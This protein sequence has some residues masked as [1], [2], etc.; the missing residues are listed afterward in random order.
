[1][2]DQVNVAFVQQYKTNVELLLQQMGSRLRRAVTT[3]TYTGKAGKSVE[4]V[5]PVNAVKRTTR[6]GD[7][8][9][10]STP[11]DARWVFP[12]DYEWADLIDDQDKVRMLID[13]QSPYARNGANALGR[14]I[15]NEIIAAFF[16][17][18]Y[19]GEDGTGTVT[20]NAENSNNQVAVGGAGLTV[21]KLR[22][23]KKYL[24]AAD[25]DVDNDEL[26]VAI[27][28]EQ[29]D[30][31]L[32]E[33]QAINLDYTNKPALVDGRITAFMGFNFIHT[34]LLV[35]DA[36]PD[37]RV[38]CWAKSGMHLGV[39]NDITTRIEERADKS[40][41]TQV[42]VKGTFGATRLEGEKVVEIICDEA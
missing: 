27:T 35:E 32:N 19:V 4:Q 40:F 23:A 38:P 29:H 28:A 41:S 5:G 14:A 12:V 13:P 10:V 9:L 22:E 36:T 26:F 3:D 8:P 15:D 34:E 11:H 17:T 37:R 7:T 16:A 25:V 30:D 2:S 39:W 18:A 33:T 42:Y 24:M 6:H 21:A 1:M 31:L 20:H